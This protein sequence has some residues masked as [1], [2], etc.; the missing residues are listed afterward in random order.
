[1]FDRNQ[2]KPPPFFIFPA[3]VDTIIRWQ[4]TMRDSPVTIAEI[5]AFYCIF[6]APNR[7]MQALIQ[8]G[9]RSGLGILEKRRSISFRPDYLIPPGLI[10]GGRGCVAEAI[11]Y[12]IIDWNYQG[13]F[14]ETSLHQG[15]R[16]KVRLMDFPVYRPKDGTGKIKV[17]KAQSRVSAKE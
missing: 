13:F 1:L 5:L 12:R 7:R 17:L 4:C 2:K 8:A 10:Y 15:A 16:S 14:A 9:S 6:S 11:Q 3:C